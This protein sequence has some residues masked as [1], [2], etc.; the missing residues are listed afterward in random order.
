MC[1]WKKIVVSFSAVACFATTPAGV[2]AGPPT[3][4]SPARLVVPSP[5]RIGDPFTAT[6]VRSALKGAAKRLE[7]PRCQQVFGDFRDGEGRTLQENLLELGETGGSYM[8]KMLFYDGGDARLCKRGS[9]LAFTT[10]GSRVVMVCARAFR[11]MGRED[12]RVAEA[13]LIHEALHSLGLG[14][15]PP[16]SQAITARVLK[17]CRH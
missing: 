16:T 17:M 7:H 13:V 6:V 2:R 1:A 8:E 5:V 10:P 14:E 9:V 3:D 15:N 4:P 11:E 12:P